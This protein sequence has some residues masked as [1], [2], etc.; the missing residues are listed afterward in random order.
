M[1]VTQIW[2]SQHEA[3]PRRLGRHSGCAHASFVPETKGRRRGSP[4]PPRP[5]CPVIGALSRG[6][7]P[8]PWGRPHLVLC[9]LWGILVARQR[10]V[11]LEPTGLATRPGGAARPSRRARAGSRPGGW[12]DSVSWWL[13]PQDTQSCCRTYG[14]VRGRHSLQGQRLATVGH[15]AALGPSESRLRRQRGHGPVLE[16]TGNRQAS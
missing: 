6:C 4:V 15:R 3:R 1:P 9:G 16:S 14:R 8:T 13:R 7:P 5:R 11:T 2:D 12:T 10:V